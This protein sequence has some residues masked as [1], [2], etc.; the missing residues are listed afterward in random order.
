MKTLLFRFAVAVVALALSGCARFSTPPGEPPAL[1]PVG[2]GASAALDPALTASTG[3]SAGSL[4][5]D[6]AVSLYRDR[7][8]VAVGDIV[9]V[10]IDV[11]DQAALRSSSSRNRTSGAGF[12]LDGEADIFGV[13]GEG[14]ISFNGTGQTSS[15]G[16]G[17]VQR[18]ERVSLSVAA[19]VTAA[20][21]NGNLAIA[22]LQE[23]RVNNEMR[24][25]GVQ[26]VVRLKDITPDNTIRYDQIAEARVTYGGA[27]RIAEVQQPTILHQIYDRLS[28]M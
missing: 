2:S 12:G 1:S 25:L 4:W 17:T 3:G 8:A 28:P 16:Q 19:T 18:S 15:S 21:P 6:S 26:G 11:D 10:L 13:T 9:T 14:E 27:G 20:L 5:R 22:G 24:V 7:R 23:M